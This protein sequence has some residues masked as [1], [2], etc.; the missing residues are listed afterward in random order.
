MTSSAPA[1]PAAPAT[2]TAHTFKSLAQSDFKTLE[3]LLA[4]GAAPKPSD[5]AGYEWRGWNVLAPTSKPVA[6][7]MG[8]QRF[9]KGFFVRPDVG[10]ADAAPFIEG[11]NIKI[12]RGGLDD[13]WTAKGGGALER[14]AFY[15]VYGPA[16]GAALPPGDPARRAGRY[17]NALFLDYHEGEPK[18]GLFTGDGLRDFVV[19]LAPDLL[20]GKAYFTLGPLTVVGGFFVAERWQKAD[21]V[22]PASA[23]GAAKAA[24]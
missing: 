11:Y 9:A 1:A 6:S 7:L 24:A 21:F 4:A 17:P 23:A 12:G 2:P 14:F 20:L 16:A 19:Q 18:N 10:S 22:P 15:R 5:I 3:A 13:P 8:I